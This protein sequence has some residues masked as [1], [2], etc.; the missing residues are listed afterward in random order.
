MAVRP[1]R[2]GCGCYR[3]KVRL[4]FQAI[5]SADT[6]PDGELYRTAMLDFGP[7]PVD[8][9]LGGLVARE[10]CGNGAEL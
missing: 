2:G 1:C 9:W 5:S 6:A 3:P 8:G 7:S 10:L 4:G